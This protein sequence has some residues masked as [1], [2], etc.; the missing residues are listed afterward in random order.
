MA[1]K[2]PPVAFIK[3]ASP[4]VIIVSSGRQV[5]VRDREWSV[6]SRSIEVAVGKMCDQSIEWWGKTGESLNLSQRN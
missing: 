2:P 5:S 3:R 4:L 1:R 6:D